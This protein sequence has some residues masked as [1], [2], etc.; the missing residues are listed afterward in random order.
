M[1]TTIGTSMQTEQLDPTYKL[2]KQS[3]QSPNCA[4]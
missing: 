1:H 3:Q 2:N 4:N